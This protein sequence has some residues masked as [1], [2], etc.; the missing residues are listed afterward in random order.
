[1]PHKFDALNPYGGG[2]IGEHIEIGL[3]V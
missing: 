3:K 1:M 2:K